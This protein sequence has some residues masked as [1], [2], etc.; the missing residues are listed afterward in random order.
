MPAASPA[1]L[2]AWQLCLL[3]MAAA[4]AAYALISAGSPSTR[5]AQA[6]LRRKA[7]KC[8][9][10]ADAEAAKLLGPQNRAYHR[11][12]AT[13]EAQAQSLFDLGMVAAHGFN[14]LEAAHWFEVSARL[15]SSSTNES[16]VDG[17]TGYTWEGVGGPCS[18]SG[19]RI[20]VSVLPMSARDG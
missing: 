13:R 3:L 14:Q 12:I 16:V 11:T 5:A 6:L 9:A 7:P 15:E 1:R 8:Y 2:A 18:V 4:L 19:L 17:S 20:S 10:L